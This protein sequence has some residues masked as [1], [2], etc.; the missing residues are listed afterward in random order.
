[1]SDI[2]LTGVPTTRLNKVG[3]MGEILPGNVNDTTS[4]LSPFGPGNKGIPQ[5]GVDELGNQIR[6]VDFSD[7]NTNM[8]NMSSRLQDFLG[9]FL[10][11]FGKTA[12]LKYPL[13]TENPAYQARVRF[14]VFTFRPKDGESMK[15]F[16]NTVH[17]P[18]FD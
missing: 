11:S 12:D 3:S 16:A 5:T 8:R 1:M 6:N 2:G 4:S 14:T 9:G 18:P 15:R 10:S 13:E 7:L 17:R